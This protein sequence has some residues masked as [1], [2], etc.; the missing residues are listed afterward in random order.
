MSGARWERTV[1]R[2]SEMSGVIEVSE[3]CQIKKYIEK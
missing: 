1:K 3:V 2:V